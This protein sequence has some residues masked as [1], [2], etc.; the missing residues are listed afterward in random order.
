MRSRYSSPLG[1]PIAYIKRGRVTGISI[2]SVE[3]FLFHIGFCALELFLDKRVKAV[4]RA[5]VL[6]KV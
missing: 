4:F 6:R 2:L 1:R 5:E 3:R